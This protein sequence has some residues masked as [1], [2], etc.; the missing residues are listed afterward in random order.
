M[1]GEGRGE[2]GVPVVHAVTD[3]SIVARPDFLPRARDVMT[4]LGAR[5]AL[6][7]RARSIGARRL[8]ELARALSDLRRPSG[9]WLVVNDRLDVALATE[10][11][12]AQLTSRS[13]TIADARRVAPTLPL[14][15]SV[16]EVAEA[17]RASHQGEGEGEG[18]GATWIVAGNV[19]VTETHPG[20][21]AKGC[22]FLA[23]IVAASP[24]PCVA[25]GG[26]RPIHVAG[27]VGRGAH[28]VAAIGGIWRS[29]DAGRAAL[30]YLSAYDAA[31]DHG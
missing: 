6:Q 20:T 4:A 17:E 13:L 21:A 14:G 12:G 27:L 22:D 11:D 15:A 10:A 2:R 24:L 7:L 26:V 16:H 31:R 3:D 28:G 29:G 19:F 8:Y 9:C 23:A 30:D 18:E 1:R 25:I 5:G